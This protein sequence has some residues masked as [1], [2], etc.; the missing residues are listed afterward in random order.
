MRE[1]GGWLFSSI[2]ISDTLP[3]DAFPHA[4]LK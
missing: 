3:F 2:M 4:T 1:I